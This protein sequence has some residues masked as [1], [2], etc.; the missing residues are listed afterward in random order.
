MKRY[1]W[2]LLGTALAGT[3]LLR[4]GIMRAPDRSE[5]PVAPSG[6][7]TTLTLA[8]RAGEIVPS[9]AEVPL[10]A[11]VHLE[12]E[13]SD[14]ETLRVSLG[15]YEDR[16]SVTIAPGRVGHVSFV[17]D[18]PGEDFPWH[19]DGQALGRLSVTG[20]HLVEGHR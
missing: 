18:R 7:D 1:A 20:S 6:P 2:L 15:G 11:R 5:E 12:I 17:A 10:G 13:G 3:A 19:V 4:L 14:R 9:R 8:L 16:V